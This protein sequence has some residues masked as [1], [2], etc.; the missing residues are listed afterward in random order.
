MSQAEDLL[1][2]GQPDAA[3]AA[4]TEQVKKSPGDSKLR[5]F[6][7]QLLCIN[8]AWERALTQ[9]KTAAE[10]DAAAIP[11]R[12]MIS[13]AIACEAL[14]KDVFAGRRSPMVFGE[15]EEWLALLIESL[16]QAGAG[17][18]ALSEDLNARA[19]DAAPASSGR[20]DG[21]P[22]SWI[23]DADSRLG[24]VLE[25][26]ING[27]YYWVPFSRLSEVNTEKP[28]DLRDLVWLPARLAFTNG[29]EAFALLPV[30]YPGTETL[31]DGA[32]RLSRRT[33]WKETRPGKFVGLGQRLLCTDASEAGLLEVRNIV[34]D[35]VQAPEGEGTASP[36]ATEA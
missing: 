29:G 24:P 35:E 18:M 31:E 21:V 27:R 16:L 32:L 3:L 7:A 12:Q 19:L 20:I 14:R 13:D 36:D 34:F 28:V 1:R 23:A 9:L 8:G 30:R 33:E 10:L 17:Q 22:F 25:A 4:L 5:V 15:P 6:L 26:V 2:Q 11:M